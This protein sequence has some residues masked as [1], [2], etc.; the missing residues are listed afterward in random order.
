[1]IHRVFRRQ[2]R[3]AAWAGLLAGLLL[4]A[5]CATPPSDSVL[6]AD[7]RAALVRFVDRDPG[8]QE[9]VNQAYGYA[10]FPSLGKAGLGVGGAYGRGVVFERGQ[11]VGIAK[12]IQGTVGLQLGAQSFSMVIF[13]Q[14]QAA[15]KTFQRGNFEFSAQA[16]AVAV[17]AGAA[18][19]TSYEK[20]VAV[21]ILSRGGL[22]AEASVGGQKFEYEPL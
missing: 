17:T 15:L 1:M 19:T 22:M 10:V 18:A 11:P 2:G 13:F 6:I 8:L 20:G 9:W 14:D 21:F 5:A 16:T 12:M 7:A 3:R 4:T